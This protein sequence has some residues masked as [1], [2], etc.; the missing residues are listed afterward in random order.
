MFD[1]LPGAA[2]FLVAIR[3]TPDDPT[4][5]LVFADWLEEQ[6]EPRAPWLRDADLWPWMSPDVHDPVPGLLA[7]MLEGDWERQRRAR[8]MLEKLGPPVVEAVRAWTRAEPWPRWDRASWV[9]ESVRPPVLQ[10]VPELIEALKSESWYERW[11]A[12]IDL[13]FHG[14]AAA[15]AVPALI[16]ADFYDETFTGGGDHDPLA[17]AIIAVLQQLGPA[18]T[19]AI[20]YLYDSLER[21]ANVR[22]AADAALHAI[23][24]HDPDR[25]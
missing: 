17:E 9:L 10:P 23:G 25:M 4:H 24:P 22:E 8:D 5:R 18:A 15:P 11:Q 16:H 20:P 7:E 12:V 3:E 2:P 21:R 13:G 14:A 1:H 19:E 6:G